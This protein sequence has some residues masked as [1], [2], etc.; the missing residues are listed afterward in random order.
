LKVPFVDLGRE[1]PETF[2]AMLEALERVV[3]GG[4]FIL[5][6]E[7]AAFEQEFARYCGRDSGIGVSSGTDAIFA[8]LRALGVGDG[9]E[10]ATAANTYIATFDAISMCGATPVPVDVEP[11]Y[12][13]IDPDRLAAA[14][15]PRTKAVVPVHLFGQAA[16]MDAVMRIARENNLPV[17]EDAAQAHG[18][19]YEG[20]KCGSFGVMAC[21]SFYPAK[22]LGA[23][24]DGG[25]VVTDDAALSRELRLLRNYGQQ[26]KNV[27]EEIGFNL[28]LD[29]IQAAILRIKL[30]ELDERNDL[31]R[32]AA[33]LYR[34]RLAD[35]PQVRPP[36]ERGADS[37]HIYHL[38]VIRCEERDRLREFLAEN[39]IGTGIHYPTPPHLQPAYRGLGY[40]MGD[41]PVSEMLGDEI[42]SL[43]MFPG[44][45]AAEVDFVCDLIGSF[46]ER[47][48]A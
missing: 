24:G 3:R 46:Y 42:L 1:K 40:S 34:E 25:M 11:D 23:F 32:N 39:G 38:F 44:L 7:V 35:I 13:N 33:E 6:P 19:L 9:D 8:A 17:V 15:T 18:A 4:N 10:V 30:R 12:F 16:E 29:E 36:A 41:F 48:R 45:A 28:R 27:H 37:T 26:D 43:P 14:I 20:R 5:G 22:N 2:S 31:R 47:E 21:F